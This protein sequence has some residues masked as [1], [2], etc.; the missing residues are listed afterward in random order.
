M[1]RI[2]RAV[3]NPLVGI[4]A[5][6]V[7]PLALVHHLGRKSGRPY[8]TPVVAFATDEGYVIPMPYGTDTDWCLNALEAG[9]CTLETAGRRIEL[10]N[11]RIAESEA[12]LP[13]LP[14]VL[15]PGLRAAT[16]PGYLLLDRSPAD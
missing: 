16:L 6:A 7:P 8:R 11:P 3:T 15:Q 13:L 4:I 10:E 12:A 9:H 1:R 14:A 5:G 2:N